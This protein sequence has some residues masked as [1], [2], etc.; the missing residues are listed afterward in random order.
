MK[1]EKIIVESGVSLIYIFFLDQSGEQDL[2]LEFI[3]WGNDA[4]VK[5]FGFNIGDT[6]KSILRI[7]VDHQGLRTV[8]YVRIKSILGGSA[9]SKILGL[10][11]VE[12]TAPGAD[13]YF[14]H[15]ALLFSKNA[16]EKTSPALEIES[17]EV[18]VSHSVTVSNFDPEMI[19]YIKSRGIGENMA[20]KLVMASF[21]SEYLAE[22]PDAEARKNCEALIR[23][24]IKLL[25]K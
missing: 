6:G 4:K 13:G 25:S 7:S 14:S 16:R 8:S 12:K 3:L 9:D 5:I 11:K 19:F 22:I 15:N 21:A 1:S 18:K 24:K 10:I 2:S 20:K 23:E 17:N